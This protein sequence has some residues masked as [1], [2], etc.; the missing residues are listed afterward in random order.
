M[1]NDLV[2]ENAIMFPPLH[3]GNLHIFMGQDWGSF[4]EPLIQNF[5]TVCETLLL[6]RGSFLAAE[7]LI[8]LVIT[9]VF[10][11]SMKHN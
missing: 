1:F 9:K 8:W 4:S 5:K 2:A 11:G 3:E 6:G 10:P 7:S